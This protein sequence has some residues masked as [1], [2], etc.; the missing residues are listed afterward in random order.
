M[1][2]KI[3]LELDASDFQ[4]PICFEDFE[5][6]RMTPCGHAFCWACLLEAHSNSPAAVEP[7]PPFKCPSCRYEI[8]SILS[9]EDMIEE[10][11]HRF[12]KNVFLSRTVSE[13]RD[14]QDYIL[15]FL[16]KGQIFIFW[17]HCLI[18]AVSKRRL[19]MEV[20]GQGPRRT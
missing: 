1:A 19:L 4:C 17:F 6:P 11:K 12:F 15:Q 20:Q 5:S 2:N 18:Q 10:P 9:C 3:T 8:D 13:N 14:L 16:Y 7:F